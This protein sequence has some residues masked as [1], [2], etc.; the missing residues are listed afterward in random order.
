MS[1]EAHS[2][3]FLTAASA[4]WRRSRARQRLRVFRR[5]ALSSF[6]SSLTRRIVFL[7]LGGLLV[8]VVAFLLLNQF[9]ADIIAA[10]TQSLKTQAG[11]IAAAIAASA[12]VDTDTITVDPEKLLQ[13]APNENAERQNDDEDSI[14]FSINPE[15]VGPVL[16]R[17]V[18][19]TRTRARIYD[20]DGLLLLDSSTLSVRGP[21]LRAEASAETDLP[22]W[23]KAWSDLR[24]SFTPAKKRRAAEEWATNGKSM[25]EVAAAFD[26][27]DRIGGAASTPRTRRSSRSRRRS[28]AQ[29]ARSAAR[30]FSPPRAATSI[31]SSR[32]S[33]GRCCASSW[34]WRR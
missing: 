13:L 33:A 7:N 20:L 15:R 27:R 26:G 25:P 28:N 12:T 14:E 32:R 2:E 31:R 4:R 21:A 5:A 22:W 19:P 6:S 16:H 30:C 11:I 9:R 17:L 29:A 8:L 24:Q 3:P 18:T 23:R 10:R 34:C 1:S